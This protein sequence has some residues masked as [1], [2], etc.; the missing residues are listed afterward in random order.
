[1]CA[2]RVCTLPVAVAVAV[3][4]AA[5]VAAA[6]AAAASQCRSDPARIGIRKVNGTFV[7]AV[8]PVSLAFFLRKGVLLTFPMI[9]HEVVFASSGAFFNGKL[10]EISL[11]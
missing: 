2:V 10:V 6:A 7:R 1:M 5:A 8:I 9:S 3:A 11:N 4:V